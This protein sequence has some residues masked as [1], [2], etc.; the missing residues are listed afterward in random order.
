MLLG[1]EELDASPL[2]PWFRRPVN[3]GTT[4]VNMWGTTETTVVSTY[5]EVVEPDTRLT[6]RPIGRPLPGMSVYVLDRYGDPVPT[7]AVGETGHRR[8]DRGPRLPQPGRAECGAVRG[9]PVLRRARGPHVPHRRP[10]P[11]A[12][13]RHAGVPGPQRRPGEDP[14]IPHRTGRD[15]HPSQRAPGGRR[16]PRGGAGPGRR[17][18]P[19]RIR[20]PGPGRRAAAAP[21]PTSGS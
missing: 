1:G 8:R 9:R 20:R 2:A 12:A 15:R 18:A 19:G 21:P 5:R 17:P 10:G 4:L 3:D 7:G 13:G 14:R 16:G 6:T 11:A